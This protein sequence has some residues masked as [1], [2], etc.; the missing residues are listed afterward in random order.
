MKKLCVILA[1]G[2]MTVTMMSCSNS[3]TPE[4][5]AEKALKCAKNN[6][7]KGYLS[8]VQGAEK[9][10]E[11][12]EGYARMIEEKLKERGDAAKIVSYKILD[13]DILE[14]SATIYYQVVTKDGNEKEDSMKLVKDE[15]GEWKIYQ[16]K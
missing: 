8:L 7:W 5:V 1:V 11:Q 6:D 4:A 2:F 3:N 9:N 10:P 15:N 14:D 16:K 12:M 13:Q